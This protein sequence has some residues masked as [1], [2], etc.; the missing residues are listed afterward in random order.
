LGKHRQDVFPALSE[1]VERVKK[2]VPIWKKEFTTRDA[3]W[4]STEA[5]H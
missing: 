5:H 1:T 4:V 3:Y 2:E